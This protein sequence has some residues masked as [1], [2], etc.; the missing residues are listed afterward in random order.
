MPGT[1]TS[2][3]RRWQQRFGD[4][5]E[6]FRSPAELAAAGFDLGEVMAWTQPCAGRQQGPGEAPLARRAVVAQQPGAAAVVGTRPGQRA[7][8]VIGNDA[9]GGE[10]D[11]ELGGDVGPGGAL[12]L[13][14]VSTAAV[15][16]AVALV[17]IVQRVVD[18]DGARSAACDAGS[19][20]HRI[21]LRRELG[22][23]A[24]RQPVRRLRMVPFVHK[25]GGAG[26][27]REVEGAGDTDVD[28]LRGLQI[29]QCTRKGLVAGPSHSD[30]EQ[31]YVPVAVLAVGD[32]RR[33][34][35]HSEAA[36]EGAQLESDRRS[37][38]NVRMGCRR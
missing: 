21:D 4:P 18:G 28:H 3:L 36:G 24:R 10:G 22:I 35:V 15:A 6:G 37:E 7:V 9:H 12:H 1:M 31:G 34:S 27:V 13:H 25:P 33:R 32:G 26:G 8:G 17:G 19:V 5:V 29:A 16:D 11:A 30:G 2:A 20:E 23:G 38:Q 14:Q